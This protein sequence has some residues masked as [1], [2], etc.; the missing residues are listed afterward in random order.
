MWSSVSHDTQNLLTL[1][2][3]I[4]NP[5]PRYEFLSYSQSALK[6]YTVWFVSPFKRGNVVVNSEYI[7]SGIGTR[8]PPELLRCP[9]RYAARLSQAFTAT[10]RGLIVEED[11]IELIPDIER[12]GYCFTDGNG[13]ISPEMAKAIYAGIKGRHPTEIS[14]TPSVF[15]LRLQG[16]KGIITIDPRLD[17]LA[18][19]LRPSMVKFNSKH[20]EVE[21]ARSFERPVRFFLNKPL[22]MIL[23]GLGVAHPVFLKLQRIAVRE[24]EE[25]TKSFK[26]AAGLFETHG[27]GTP[28]SLAAIFHNLRKIGVPFEKGPE[29]FIDRFM[30]RCL[31][32]AVHH[33]LR[34][35]KT[36]GRI[37]VPGCWK[38]VG[39]VD[40]YNELAPDEIFGLWYICKMFSKCG[41]TNLSFTKLK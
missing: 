3:L 26:K 21:I 35:M 17:G 19:Q 4:S 20:S 24:A 41:F 25:S 39:T 23:G 13:L 14:R 40:V 30:D 15:Q 29:K 31:Q 5:F 7:R 36:R 37:P 38:L 1:V 34:E 11:Q 9:A 8:W 10:D 22:T 18:L 16:A 6:D 32:Y 2:F 28:F 33:V 12:N 27:L